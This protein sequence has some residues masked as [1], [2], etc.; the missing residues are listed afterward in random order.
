MA[1]NKTAGIRTAA[2]PCENRAKMCVQAGV[3]GTQRNAA[4]PLIVTPEVLG[5]A[6]GRS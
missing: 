5:Q 4:Q 1:Q 2:Q 6:V 3:V